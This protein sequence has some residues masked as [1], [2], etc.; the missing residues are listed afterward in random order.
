MNRLKTEKNVLNAGRFVLLLI[1]FMIGLGVI[2]LLVPSLSI[3]VLTAKTSGF[4]LNAVGIQNQF[5]VEDTVFLKLQ[6]GSRIVFNELCTGVLETIV[7]VAAILASFE[8]SWKKRIL[9]A[10]VGIVGIFVFNQ[11]RIV[12]TVFLILNAP[13]E[14]VELSHDVFFRVFLFVAIAVFYAV[15]LL[16]SRSMKTH[17]TKS[18]NPGMH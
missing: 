9:G 8:I 2:V 6:N 10:L 15:F 16:A 5:A 17:S 14:T 1:G 18:K 4:V 11:L 7:L 3:E 13:I 12:S